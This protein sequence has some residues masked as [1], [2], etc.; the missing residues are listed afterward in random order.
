M[1]RHYVMVKGG[2]EVL[3]DLGSYGIFAK[4]D[5]KGNFYDIT[6]VGIKYDSAGNPLNINA[7]P[8]DMVFVNQRDEGLLVDQ[9]KAVR[10]WRHKQLK[11]G[12]NGQL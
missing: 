4:L 11:R 3:I 9:A 6:Y 12:G 1:K 5:K 8:A 7:I 10:I 2:D